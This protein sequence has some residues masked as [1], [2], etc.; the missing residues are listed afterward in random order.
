LKK[1]EID[2]SVLKQKI[3][4][5]NSAKETVSIQSVGLQRVTPEKAPVDDI[6]D[7]D[8]DFTQTQ[9]NNGDQA[10][11]TNGGLLSDD[12]GDY[13][14]I[15]LDFT[16]P[17]PVPVNTEPAPVQ[18]DFDLLD[19]DVAPTQTIAPVQNAQPAQSDDLL[20]FEIAQHNEPPVQQSIQKEEEDFSI[21]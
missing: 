20:D 7:I 14:I 12:K 4:D 5:F 15:D 10:S 9:T 19:F 13:N 11:Q 17:N 16:N 6:L 1:A 2:V 21:F 3:E 18:D 8:V